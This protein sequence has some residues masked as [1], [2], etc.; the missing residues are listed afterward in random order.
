VKQLFHR[1][2]WQRLPVEWRRRA[3]FNMT[4]AIAPKPTESALGAEPI[5]VAGALRSATGL[6]ESARLCHD[7]LQSAGLDVYGV[8]LSA[9]LMQPRDV[10][11]SYRDGREVAGPGTV[12]D[13]VNAPLMPFAAYLLGH[14]LIAG[15]HIVGYWAWE[16]PSVPREWLKGI[17]FVHEVWAPSRFTAAA[18][19]P[20]AAGRPVRVVP[21]PVTVRG[22][23]SIAREARPSSWAFTVLTI[24]DMGSSFAR[25]NPLASIRAFRRAFNDDPSARLLVKTLNVDVFDEGQ[26]Q[27][28]ESIGSATN[29]DLVD[30]RMSQTELMELYRS[31]DVLLSLHRSE[32]F[33]LTIAEAMLSGM[34][35]IATNWSGNTDFLSIETGFPIGYRLVPAGDP[36]RTYHQ[37]AMTWAEA[38]AEAAAKALRALRDEPFLR[39]TM[40]Q[41][42]RSYSQENWSIERYSDAV[43]SALGI[44]RKR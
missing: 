15:K 17:A 38:D 9:S 4:A 12:I 25:K 27:L 31:A 24:F 13:H 34:P 28:R 5:I 1:V 26:R 39:A 36:Q 30:K 33:G 2:V 11:F 43:L 44:A 14:K 8:D 23:G 3:L 20:I 19:A 29:I 7:A 42:A 37:P 18:I 35:I 10:E 41:A 40:G 22:Y 16:L 32:G 21:H 6:G